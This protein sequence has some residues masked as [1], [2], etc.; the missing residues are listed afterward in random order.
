[1]VGKDNKDLIVGLDVGTSKVMVV[2]GELVEGDIRLAGLGV[3]DA[4]G[5]KRGVVE[6]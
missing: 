3:A 2:V 1:M 6:H 4:N 5:L